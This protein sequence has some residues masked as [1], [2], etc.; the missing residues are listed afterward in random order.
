M[1][2]L[3]G[4]L[5]NNIDDLEG[6]DVHHYVD[7]GPKAKQSEIEAIIKESGVPYLQSFYERKTTVLVET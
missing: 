1:Q 5:A 7:G 3:L 2:E 4:G 6:I